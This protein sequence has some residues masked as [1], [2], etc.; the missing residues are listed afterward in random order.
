[1]NIQNV[2]YQVVIRIMGKH[3]AAKEK[4]LLRDIGIGILHR[5]GKEG[6]EGEQRLEARDWST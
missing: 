5:M 3:K 2:L 6:L 1:M 4:E